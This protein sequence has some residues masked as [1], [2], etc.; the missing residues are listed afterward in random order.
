[1]NENFVMKHDELL[2]CLHERDFL[3]QMEK[4]RNGAWGAKWRNEENLFCK[5][6]EYKYGSFYGDMDCD[7]SLWA[8]NVYKMLHK[9]A[10]AGYEIKKQSGKNHIFEL[11]KPDAMTY[12]GDT[13]TSTIT[14]LKKYLGFLWKSQ[15]EKSSFKDLFVGVQEWG[16][17]KP[18]ENYPKNLTEYFKENAQIIWEIIGQDVGAF[19]RANFKAGAYICIPGHSYKTTKKNWESFNT[20]W[21]GECYAEWDTADMKLWRIYQYF[22]PEEGKTGDIKPAFKSRELEGQSGCLADKLADDFET[23]LKDFSTPTW[24]EFIESHCLQDFVE[25]IEY[26]D[27]NKVYGKPISLKTGMPIACET[28]AAY[29]AMPSC[30]DECEL[31][32]R[33]AG[34]LIEKCS[35]RII[36]KAGQIYEWTEAFAPFS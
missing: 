35:K 20:G 18:P 32:F 2:D 24:T 16:D 7:M 28:N 4:G 30:L 1:M 12:R 10:L 6:W 15:D 19:F 22:H 33:T 5:F 8:M 13:L 11:I 17:P 36:D 34:R 14:V 25:C 29:D 21:A 3:V 26:S 9:N 27:E 23:W 31:F